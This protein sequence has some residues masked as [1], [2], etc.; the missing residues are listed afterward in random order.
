ME[1]RLRSDANER[2]APLRTPWKQADGCTPAEL[3]KRCMT[4]RNLADATALKVTLRTP[5]VRLCKQGVVG[6]NPI[7]STE[8]SWS[9]RAAHARP[10]DT[11]CVSRIS[12]I[13]SGPKICHGKPTIRGLRY[14]VAG[15]HQLLAGGS[16]AR[17]RPDCAVPRSPG[18]VSR[19]RTIAESTGAGARRG[20]PRCNPH[21][22]VARRQPDQGRGTAVGGR[23]RGPGACH[24]GRR[25]PRQPPSRRRTAPASDCRH[26]EYPQ[27]RAA[28][29]V[30]RPPRGLDRCLGLSRSRRARRVQRVDL[31]GPPRAP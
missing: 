22:R 21:V 10:P 5:Y 16:T 28:G 2:G 8:T 31:R 27:Q 9:D 11:G 30:R 25:L 7:V 6:S 29:P 12:R 19:R 18:E 1:S 4:A 26:R 23:R 24:K 20:R 3:R 15:L 14:P 13:T 17:W